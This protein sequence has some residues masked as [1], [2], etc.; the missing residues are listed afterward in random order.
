[1]NSAYLHP[2]AVMQ[3]WKIPDFLG[4]M[5]A[6]HYL[7]HRVGRL[8]R[9]KAQRMIDAGDFR[10]ERGPLKP[11]RRLWRGEVVELWRFPPDD[12]NEALPEVTII[13]E[14]EDFIVVNKPAHLTIH[15]TAQHLYQTLTHWFRLNFPENTPHPCHRLDRETSGVLVA[16]K[17][18][19]AQSDIKRAFMNGEVEK[20][21]LALVIGHMKEA[22]VA[23]W[24]LALQ[25]DR[26]LVR[27]RMIRDE[28]G[29]PSMTYF[30]PLNYN[31]ELNQTLVECR[32]KTGRQ[33]Q[34][35]AHLAGEGF[36]IVDDKLYAMGDEFFDARSRWQTDESHELHRHALHA[37]SISFR[38]D[39]K[40]HYFEA[41]PVF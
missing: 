32:P 28:D 15:P 38:F 2:D 6:D 34:I 19:R 12:P 41:P 24:P 36:P 5:R 31:A 1:M 9:C 13:A 29:M 17:S 10:A 27:I 7:V 26:G 22:L 20:V 8:S 3:R 21:Y 16:A 35:R 30:K 4:G 39:G 40:T 11:S 25:G 37:F 18:Q 23:D 14:N 33:H